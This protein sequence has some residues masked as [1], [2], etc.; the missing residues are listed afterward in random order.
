M[1]ARRELS[2]LPLK[3]PRA[4]QGAHPQISQPK[5][6]ACYSR[7]ADRT[8]HFDRR[9]LRTYR[10]PPLPVQLDE[11]FETFVEKAHARDDPAP[12]K[13]VLGALASKGVDVA[14]SHIV[15][16]RNNLNKLL[17]T[18]FQPDDDWEIGVER[19][20]GGRVHLQVRETARKAAEEARRDERQRRFCYW[21]YKFEA[22]CTAD[23][24]GGGEREGWRPPSPSDLGT[25]AHLC[26]TA[27]L[28]RL[29]AH[30]AERQPAPAAPAAAVDANEEVCCVMSLGLER[31][32]ILMA[33]EIDCADEARDGGGGGFVELKTSKAPRSARDTANFERNKLLRYWV[34]SFLA[35]VPKIVVGFRDDQGEVTSVQPLRTMQIPR[36]VR[37]KPHG[38]DPSVALRFGHTVLDWVL[39]EA[40]KLPADDGAQ[41][42]LRFE[43]AERALVLY[44]T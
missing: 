32:K 44:A 43:P 12:L 41:L 24:D 37:G 22:L 21:G 36:M 29:R 14:A 20:G 35:G 16:Y 5:E 7:D 8:V 19:Q 6:V 10:P 4:Y 11:G 30:Y 38:W 3:E 18:P 2:R 31:I 27:E 28:S 26:S 34:Q 15:T 9:A 1:A 13:D 23:A 40:A 42:V 39:R 17:L 33:A 25:C